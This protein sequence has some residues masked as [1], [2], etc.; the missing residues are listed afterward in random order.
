MGDLIRPL[1]MGRC[2]GSLKGEAVNRAGLAP[3]RVG[4]SLRLKQD[5]WICLAMLI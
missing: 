4:M 5:F 3:N 1:K 2:A